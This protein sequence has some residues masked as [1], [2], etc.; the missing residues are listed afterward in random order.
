MSKLNRVALIAGFCLLFLAPGTRGETIHLKNG[1]HLSGEV[2]KEKPEELV[3]DLGFIVITVPQRAIERVTTEE[4]DSP[5]AEDAAPADEIFSV[6]TLK[7][8]SV[9]E[10][11]EQF[12]SG[13]VMVSTPGGVGS[14]FVISKDGFVL[15]N[16]HVIQGE[17]M[18]SI[19]LFPKRKESKGFDRRTMK[20]IKIVAVNPFVDLALLKIEDLEDLELTPLFL[21]KTI[22][23][24][25]GEPVFAVGN[26]LGL[27]RTVSEGIISTTK[28]NFGGLLY[29]QTTA[30]INPGN[31]GGPLFNMRGEVIGVTNMKA[32]FF[33]EGLSFAVPIEYVKHFLRN[34]DSFAYDKDNPNTGYEYL[35]PPRRKPAGEA[36]STDQAKETSETEKEGKEKE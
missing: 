13:V 3:V 1:N 32:G 36:E 11:V 15:T 4:E 22:E 28:R 16:N 25:Q 31:S 35:P 14:G 33:T 30:P 9:K 27:E 20:K 26:P 24:K 2:L 8:T 21:G 6:A 5:G 19:T 10:N 12:S 29:L 34:R 18:I 23:A 7:L 17:Q